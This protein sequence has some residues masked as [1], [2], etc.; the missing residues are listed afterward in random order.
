MSEIL[1]TAS[2]GLGHLTLN[3][4]K[5]LHALTTRMC[6][7][8]IQA[9]T[10]WRNDDA[11]KVILLDHAAAAR[12]ASARAAIFACWPR[13]AQ[14]MAKPRANSST[15]SIGSTIFCSTIPSRWWR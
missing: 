7:E 14:A 9:L 2:A 8:M 13:A 11:I 10:Q 15:P 3:R 5:A 12:A 4:P 1:T 6:A